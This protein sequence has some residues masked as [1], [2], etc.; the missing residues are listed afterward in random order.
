M[1]GPFS[2]FCVV[3]KHSMLPARRLFQLLYYLPATLKQC[4]VVEY[5]SA[6]EL[7]W[8][9][10]VAATMHALSLKNYFQKTSFSLIKK[11]KNEAVR[12]RIKML[13]HGILAHKKDKYEKMP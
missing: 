5:R 6:Y 11:Y 10:A 9:V 7:S 3:N 12:C 2:L 13:L 1:D 8:D 4:R